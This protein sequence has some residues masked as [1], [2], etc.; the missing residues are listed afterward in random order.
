MQNSLLKD[1]IALVTGSNRGIGRQ[2]SKALAAAGA[3]VLLGARNLDSLE[4]VEDEIRAAGGDCYKFELDVTN[5]VQV[6]EVI[7]GIVETHGKLDLLVNNAG[8]GK[9]GMLPWEQDVDEWWSVQEVNLRGVFLC[10]HAA[11]AHMTSRGSGRIVDIGSLVGGSPN[12][13]SSAYA[14]S[15]VG[16]QRL[17]SCFAAAASDFGVS[18]FTVSP[19]LVA[20]DMTDDPFFKAI[21]ADQWTPI[22]KSGELVVSLATGK[23]D[24]LTGRFIHAGLHDLEELIE[25]TDEI[26]EK[27][28]LTLR[29]DL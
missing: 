16:V 13:M 22:Q 10:S 11:L 4:M 20:T 6:R 9:G 8:I 15:K 26:L 19:G 18:I 7:D 14:V 1:Q 21:P 2:V 12:P 28:L 25:R 27:D 3:T 29:V 5:S 17:S 24:R 23:A